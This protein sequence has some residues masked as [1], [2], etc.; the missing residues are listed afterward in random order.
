MFQAY[1]QLE[2]QALRK[3]GLVFKE[4]KHGLHFTERSGVKGETVV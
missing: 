1:F 4:V 2:F 3:I